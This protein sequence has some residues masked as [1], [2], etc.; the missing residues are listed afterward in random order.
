MLSDICVAVASDAA[1]PPK[2]APPA[3]GAVISMSF[4]VFA[5]VTAEVLPA[6]L[7]RPLA[8]GLG[9]TEG[10]AGQAVT[11]TAFVGLLT[12]LFISTVIGR[13]DRRWVLMA[14]S[15][16]LVAAN[17]IAASAQGIAMLLL[18]RILTGIALG[19]FW[20][21][22]FAV[23][24]RLVPERDAP[25]ALS[26]MFMGVS[27]ATVLAIPMGVYLGGLVGWRAVFVAAAGLALSALLLQILTLP[28]LPAQGRA[29]AGVLLEVLRRPGV[30]VGMTA[31]LL[32]FGGHFTFFTYLRPFLETVT[33][34]GIDGVGL[35]L[36]GFGVANLL[37][38]YWIAS[39][40]RRSLRLALVLLPVVMAAT[41]IALTLVGGL[42]A[43]VAILI[44]FWGVA[45]AGVPVSWSTWVT[46]SVP[47]QTEAGG[48]LIV[49]AVSLA[50]AVGAGLG[51]AIL[52]LAG[53][54]SVFLA[55]GVMLAAAAMIAASRVKIR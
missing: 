51:G 54:R 7:L 37:G 2:Q 4:G 43:P 12:S 20:S 1:R 49:A 33:G 29:R 40:I 36:L 48:S 24:I 32:A 41:A 53:P 9:V 8:E 18:G 10:A 3:W 55:S 6:S 39:V 17:V 45:S 50:T 30:G 46:R 27:A 16:L 5:L 21:L 47:D 13:L 44:A 25:R 52:D 19:G 42:S 22:S 14:F 28:P 23:L 34:L 26:I 15:V 38:A 31:A 11:V 35:I